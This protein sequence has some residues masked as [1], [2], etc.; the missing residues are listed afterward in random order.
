VTQLDRAWAIDQ[1]RQF[2]KSTDQVGYDNKAG[3][4]VVLGTHQRGSQVEAAGLAH[5]A[6]QVLDRVIPTWPKQAPSSQRNKETWNHLRDWAGRA[7]AQL[8]REEELREKLGDNAPLLDAAA[9]HAWVWDGV[10][11]LWR[12]GHFRQAVDQAAIHLNAETQSKVGRR[13]LSET[14]LFQQVFSTD[15]PLPGKPRLRLLQDDSGDTFKN[16]H[17]GAMAMAEGLYAAIRNPIAHEVGEEL[18]EQE[19]LEQLAAFSVLA[20]WVDRAWV[21][22]VQ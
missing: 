21:V 15:D 20:R 13:D 10:A 12:T 16:V 6:E 18:T 9:L 7:I 19:A 1:L 4:V 14:K 3:G 17:R 5:V 11:S 22:S 8:E 2:L